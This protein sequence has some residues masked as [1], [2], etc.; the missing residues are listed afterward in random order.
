MTRPPEASG[1]QAASRRLLSNT[2]IVIAGTSAQ[3]VLHFATTVLLARGL[4]GELYGQFVFVGAYMFLFSFFVD[5]GFERVIAREVA[6][7]PERAGELLGAGLLIRGVL[8][9]LAALA[10]VA[11]ATILGLPSLTWWCILISAVGLPLSAEALLR[12]FFQARFEMHYPYMLTLPGGVAFVALAIL[13]IWT[14]SSLVW[15]FVASLVTGTIS[16]ALMLWIALPKMQV[17][18]RLNPP[19][20]RRLW[21]ESWELGAVNFIWLVALRVDQLLLY[22]LRDPAELALYSVAVK[23][24]EALNLIPESVMVTVYPLLASTELTAPQRFERIYRL[25]LRYLI[26]AALPLAMLLMLEGDLIISALFGA[27]YAAGGSALIVLAWWM[28]FAYTGAVYA[29]LMIVRSQ[30]RLIALISSVALAINIGLN[31]V[32]IPRWGATGA[33]FATLASSASS[34]LLFSVAPPSRALMRV[35]W[36]E[37]LRPLAA[38]A[39]T[40]LLTLPAPTSWRPFLV[41]PAYVVLLFALGAVDREDW[42]FA[43]RTLQ[44]GPREK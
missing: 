28:F 42:A 33:A 8:S 11:L 17:T 21:R 14:E 32:L 24:T 16:I 9:L 40:A 12:A 13:V 39:A 25:T 38:I 4:G 7:T 34:F 22:W 23:I 3:R 18:W 19:L 44:A 27:T 1:T 35:C 37:A 2:M 26:V 10:A 15:V 20:L 6:R 43:R 31:L 5:L 29:N 41:L 30:H 36:T